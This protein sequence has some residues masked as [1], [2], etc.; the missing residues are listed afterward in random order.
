MIRALTLLPSRTRQLQAGIN[1]SK[2]NYFSELVASF[3]TLMDL[4][5]SEK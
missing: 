5:E 3:L 4:E 1:L 2:I